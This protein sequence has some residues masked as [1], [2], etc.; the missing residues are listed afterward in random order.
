MISK[1]TISFQNLISWILPTHK[2]RPRRIAWLFRSMKVLRNIHES[3]LTFA[4]N[5]IDQALIQ[6]QVIILENYLIERFGLGIEIVPQLI[7]TDD[8][9][10][11]DDEDSIQGAH[12]GDDADDQNLF[13]ISSDDDST[14]TGVNAIVNVPA[15]LNV[16]EIELRTVL[17]KYKTPGSTYT[18]NYT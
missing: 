3:F 15:A 5:R 4:Q 12:V 16:D 18:I 8:F 1:Y 10:I 7:N 17:N 6:P 2:R 11:A 14:G 9:F 13:F